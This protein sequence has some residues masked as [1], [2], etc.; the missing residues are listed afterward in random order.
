[1][2]AAHYKL[3]TEDIK[4]PRRS[5]DVAFARHVAMHLLRSEAK[6]TLAEIGQHLGGR[7]HSTVL[8]GCE[9]IAAAT[10]ASPTLRRTMLELA[11]TARSA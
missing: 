7:D 1:M 5:Q 8:H 11:T 2:V 6:L 4:G 3:A 9:K 10:E